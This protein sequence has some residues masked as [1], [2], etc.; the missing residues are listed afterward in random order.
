MPLNFFSSYNAGSSVP[1][2]RI[3][4]PSQ[5]GF[6]A[7]LEQAELQRLA[8]YNEAWR[9]YYG[10]H[11][12]FKREDG[13]PL[14][15]INYF[16]KFIDK[17]VSFLVQKG[18]GIGVP[19]AYSAVTKPFLDEVW[20]YNKKSKLNYE[21]ATTGSV[22]GDCFVLV[23]FIEPTELQKRLNPH[24]Q[25]RVK[26]NLYGSE[27]VF[28]TW[29]PMD[30]DKLLSVRIETIYYSADEKDAVSTG[31]NNNQLNV[32]RFTQIITREAILEQY[33]GAPPVVKPN[34]LGEIPL[35]H[36]K[37]L[38]TPHEYYGISDGQDLLDLQR[39]LNEKAT[40][41]SDT[42]NYHSSPNLAIFGAKAKNLERS[43]KSIWSGLP[44]NA[45]IETI[46]LDGDLT[47][48]NG[49]LDRI[50]R[51]MHEIGDVPEG[52]LG[53][54]Q[55]ISNTSG[56][57]LHMQH[58]PLLERRA[59]KLATYQPGYEEINYF[60][61]RIGATQGLIDLHFDVCSTCGGRIVQ[62]DTGKRKK[63]WDPELQAY[64]D[65]PVLEKRCYEIDKQSLE[66]VDPADM[67]VKFW[68]QY[69]FG[70]ELRTLRM[71]D[72]L[73]QIR[74]QSP[75]YWDYTSVQKE[76]LKQ[77]YEQNAEEED[78]EE[79]KEPETEGTEEPEKEEPEVEEPK[80]PEEML[81][82]KV[83]KPQPPEVL[84]P[85]QFNF[86]QIEVPEEPEY[87]TVAKNL[88]HPVSG[89]LLGT[90]FEE[91][92]LV[93]TG[94]RSP[95]YLDPFTNT[96]EFLEPLPKDEA[97]QANLFA[98]Y[99]SNNWVDAEWCQSKIPAIATDAQEIRKR[100]KSAAKPSAVQPTSFNE[101]APP[102][103]M[104]DAVP[105]EGGNPVSMTQQ[106]R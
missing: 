99:Q 20:R 93:P 92:F 59:R 35:V 22:T 97:L 101:N 19:E 46:K 53:Q 16:R 84:L 76:L 47:A 52:S 80:S 14:V 65:V 4:E 67:F 82:E 17:N 37:N 58:G 60:I 63:T 89:V 69:G 36:I 7:S 68:R 9:F 38:P 62:V 70:K 66:F 15:T 90:E 3:S 98:I 26:L 54:M 106:A 79:E 2:N 102:E 55:P 32:R 105:G 49:Y 5:L 64:I 78:E 74:S 57:A 18:F 73:T 104:L 87:V 43:A 103:E 40:D 50:K 100:M 21:I 77:W 45:R 28:P 31:H 30:K 71:K 33:H 29:D 91:K 75:S 56:V 81:K 24:S 41:I 51:A 25:G 12:L 27:Q 42:V 8:R 94:C 6:F 39:E 61:L 83:T 96:V 10:R 85:A 86:D 48:A 11:W 23:T 1:F 34:V 44:S 88:I 95:K 72:V 13:E